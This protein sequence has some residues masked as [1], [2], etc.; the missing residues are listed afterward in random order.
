VFCA[1]LFRFIA[2][3]HGWRVPG[4]ASADYSAEFGRAGGAVVNVITR[5]GTNDFHGSIYDVINVSS[6]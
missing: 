4:A 5:R 1:G 6:T 2:H 3:P